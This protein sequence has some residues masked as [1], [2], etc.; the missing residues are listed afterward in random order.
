MKRFLDSEE[1]NFCPSEDKLCNNSEVID[2]V[3]VLNLRS[4]I[5]YITNNK[6]SLQFHLD[7]HSQ[8]SYCLYIL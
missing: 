5:F 7:I 8:L 1:K 6:T 3:L 4:L 2:P